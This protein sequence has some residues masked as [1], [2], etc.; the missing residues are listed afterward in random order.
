M[1]HIRHGQTMPKPIFAVQ[2]DGSLD[3]AK[4]IAEWFLSWFDEETAKQISKHTQF[5]E[6]FN[7]QRRLY[8]D[9]QAITPGQWLVRNEENKFVVEDHEDFQANYELLDTRELRE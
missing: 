6:S 9:A 3:R 1:I 2:W 7:D 4:D 5:V 8:L